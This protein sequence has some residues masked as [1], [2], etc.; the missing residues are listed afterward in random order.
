MGEPELLLG[1]RA[2]LRADDPV[3]LLMVIGSLLAAVDP[4]G[5]SPFHA[6][7]EPT[8]TLDQLV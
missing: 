6:D 8:V 1:L 2:A 3:D 7:D 5:E 4:R